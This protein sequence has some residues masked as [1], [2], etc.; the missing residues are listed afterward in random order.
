MVFWSGFVGL[1]NFGKFS[2]KRL[3]LLPNEALYQAE[4]RPDEI[5]CVIFMKVNKS[6]KKALVT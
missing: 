4:P 3:Y 6:P 1:R 2:E 5:D